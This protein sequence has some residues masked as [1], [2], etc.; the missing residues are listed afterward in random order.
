MDHIRCRLIFLLLCQLIDLRFSI[1]IRNKTQSLC[2][3]GLGKLIFPCRIQY[4]PETGNHRISM[5]FNNRQHFIQDSVDL[6]ILLGTPC[7]R[8]RIL[9]RGKI[10]RHRICKLV[11]CQQ[12]PVPVINISSCSLDRACTSDRQLI[13]LQVILPLHDLQIEKSADQN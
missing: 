4:N 5:L 2:L 8:N 7:C 12:F 13:V 9:Y 6:L 11:I 3:T 1:Y 10:D